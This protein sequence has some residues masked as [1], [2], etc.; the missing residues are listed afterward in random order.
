MIRPRAADDFST[1]RARMEELRRERG[2]SAAPAGPPPAG[3]GGFTKLFFA[4]ESRRRRPRCISACAGKAIS[5]K[6][7]HS[8]RE[9]DALA[10]WLVAA[11]AVSLARSPICRSSDFTFS[12]R[13]CAP[14]HFASSRKACASFA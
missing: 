7:N 11:E 9:L 3:V 8:R 12:G 14:G 2:R 5:A 1:I 6:A 4:G 13:P 10:Y